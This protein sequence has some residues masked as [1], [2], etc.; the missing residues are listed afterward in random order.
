LLRLVV[1]VRKSLGGFEKGDLSEVVKLALRKLVASD[2][3]ADDDGIYSLKS[4][5]SRDSRDSHLVS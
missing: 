1:S 2:A 4:R 3:V 5:K